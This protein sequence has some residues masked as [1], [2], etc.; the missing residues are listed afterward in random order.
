MFIFASGTFDLINV[1]CKQGLK[2]ALNL[3]LNG[4]ENGNF[5]GIC[6]RNLRIDSHTASADALTI[7]QTDG[8]NLIPFTFSDE[9]SKYHRHNLNH[10]AND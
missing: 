10:N 2:S 9:R 1:I 8:L 6:K 4:I 7:S 5:D 3:F